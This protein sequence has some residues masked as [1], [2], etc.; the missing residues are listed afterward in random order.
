LIRFFQ[1]R[2]LFRLAATSYRNNLCLKGG[3]LLYALER[4]KSRPTLDLDFL[5]SK[6]RIDQGYFREVFQEICSVAYEND[7]VMFDLDNIEVQEIME[8]D[9]YTGLRVKVTANLG[10]IKQ[11]LQIDIGIGDVVTPTP[12]EM[13]YPTLLDMEAPYIQAY[14]PET[15]IAEK[16]EAMISL[17]E[18]NSRMKD[19]YDVYRLLQSERC[20]MQI[21]S[22]AIQNTFQNRGTIY[23]ADHPLF[24][25]TF[26]GDPERE[27]MWVAFIRRSKLEAG[28]EFKVVMDSIKEVLVPVFGKLK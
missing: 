8:H 18:V 20:D 7:G 25:D 1:E 19:F 28:L 22:K 12:V 2:L 3:A 5:A 24:T 9:K 21:L 26:A 13:E 10:N 23:R 11:H 6:I 14:S 4:E 17:A 27:K 15:I 16:F